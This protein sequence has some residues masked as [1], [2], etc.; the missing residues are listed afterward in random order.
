MAARQNR[1][2]GRKAP[3]PKETVS[4]NGVRDYAPM[5]RTPSQIM[6]SHV[7]SWEYGVLSRGAADQGYGFSFGLSDLP[8]SGELTALY[9]HYRLD[10]VEIRFELTGSGVSVAPAETPAGPTILI[11]PDYDDNTAPSSISVI[12]QYGQMERITLTTARPTLSRRLQPRF[13]LGAPTSILGVLGPAA[14]SKPDFINTAYPSVP[15]HGLRF[16]VSNYNTTSVGD[17]GMVLMVSFRYHLT[18]RNTR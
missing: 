7:R 14:I 3:A 12:Q 9:D 4:R 18:M 6:H 1:R 11:A 10:T 17:S 13:T 15:H 16:W 8:S 2:N 5:F